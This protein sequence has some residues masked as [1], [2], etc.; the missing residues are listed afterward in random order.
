MALLTN[1]DLVEAVQGWLFGRS[2]LASRAPDFI[3]MCEA[4][5][6]RKLDHPKMDQRATATINLNS[7]EPEF[8]S[9]PGD[10]V[11][12]KRVRITTLPGKPKLKFT[13]LHQ[14]QHLREENGDATGQPEWFAI[15]GDEMEFCPTP[16]QAYG[17]EMVYRKVVPALAAQGSGTNWLY[18]LAPDAYLY[19]ALLEAA[20]FLHEDERITVW[21]NGF[22]GAITDLNGTGEKQANNAGPLVR[23]SNRRAY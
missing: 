20:A 9:L 6:N 8:M 17:L 23:R 10:I 15:V 7:D 19:G 12:M 16:D 22:E 11:Y 3:R 21:A 2:D 4:K 5:F 13:T 18:A 1:D 14:I